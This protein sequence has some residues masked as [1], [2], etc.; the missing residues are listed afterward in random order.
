MQTMNISIPQAS[1]AENDIRVFLVDTFLYGRNEELHADAPL[2]DTVVDSHGVVELVI[3]LQDRFGIMVKDEEVTTDN[4][5]SLNRIAGFVLK[6][7]NEKR[8]N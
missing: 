6:K 4:L 8:E 5:N 2:L 1:D 3:Y 7:L